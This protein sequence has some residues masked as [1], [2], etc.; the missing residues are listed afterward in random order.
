[1]NQTIPNCIDTERN[2]LGYCLMNT[3]YLDTCRADIE[4]DDFQLDKHVTIWRAICTLYDS[5]TPVDRLTV[6]AELLKHGKHDL[7]GGLAYLIE[8]DSTLPDVPSIAHYIRQ[9]HEFKMRRRIVYAAMH[10][11]KSAQDTSSDIDSV[12]ETFGRML[13]EINKQDTHRGPVSTKDLIDQ[14]GIT[15]LLSPR[16]KGAVSLPFPRL[17]EALGGLREGQMVVLMAATSRGKTSM[18]LQITAAAA[19]QGHTPAVWAMEMGAKTNFQRMVTQISGVYATKQ[20]TTHDERDAHRRAIEQL[21]EHPVHFDTTSRSVPAFL[22]T[23]RQIR[24]KTKLG[25]AVVDHLQL[26]RSSGARNRAQE[27]SEN[28]RALKLGAMDLGIPFL[29]LSQ[30]DRGSVKGDGKIGLHSAKESGDI[31]ND[32]DVVMWIDAGELARDQ[33]SMVSLFVGKQREGPCG[34]GIP[35]V[36]RPGT[37]MFYEVGQ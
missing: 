26:I 32:A 7:C 19:E 27:V 31:E 9:L 11:S 20:F 1:M 29:V 33:D 2:V 22:A 21:I 17:Q 24:S 37:Q 16:E 6:Y 13:V 36:F 15:A 35:M 18:A 14:I 25:L 8:M 3:G 10:I 28:S 4:P 12:V 5:N 34:F 30:V 23:L